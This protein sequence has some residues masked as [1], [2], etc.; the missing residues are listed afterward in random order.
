MNSIGQYL[1]AD[2]S[3]SADTL[4]GRYRQRIVSA[5]SFKTWYRSIPKVITNNLFF[6]ISLILFSSFQFQFIQFFSFCFSFNVFNVSVFSSVTVS[7]FQS[8]APYFKIINISSFFV[9]TYLVATML[10]FAWSLRRAQLR[11]A[12]ECRHDLLIVGGGWSNAL[13]RAHLRYS[14]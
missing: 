7:N 3:A 11:A 6:G 10:S 13:S 4:G 9:K 14:T 5:N 1:G 2:V 12:A 8:N